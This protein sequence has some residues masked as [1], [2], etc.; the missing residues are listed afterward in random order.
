MDDDAMPGGRDPGGEGVAVWA[1]LLRAHAAL[2]HRFDQEL[3]RATGLPLSWYDVLLELDA[4]PGRRLRMTELGD[5]VVL[6]RS[7]VSRVVDELVA[8]GLVRREP[9]SADRR[10]ANAVLTG[11]G[12]AALRASAPTYLA[13]IDE[14][15]ARHLTA[16]QRAAMR[17][18]LH[19]VL[20]AEEALRARE[21]GRPVPL[22]TLSG[23]P[24]SAT[25]RRGRP[26]R[27]ER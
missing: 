25:G 17:A 19:Q 1:L 26:A 24:A 23:R 15:F 6:S 12:R 7:R 3:V 22:P 8:K 4:A 16:E 20:S 21:A 18:G 13:G 27:T 10:G 9:D 5:R 11:A 14:H 2:V